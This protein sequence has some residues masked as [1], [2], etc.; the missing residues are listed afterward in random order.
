MRVDSI[1]LVLLGLLLNSCWPTEDYSIVP[2]IEYNKVLFR[3]IPNESD[4][5]VILIDFQ[6]GDGD[7]GLEKDE[8][9]SPFNDKAYFSYFPNERKVVKFY[10][11]TLTESQLAYYV[12]NLITYADRNIQDLD[13]LPAFKNPYS[14]I[15]WEI[16]PDLDT[17]Y[18][19][20][21]KSHY[22]IHVDFLVQ[23]TNGQYEEF[24]WER[25]FGYPN[26]G[27]S[28]N[29][30]FPILQNDIS[31]SRPLEGTI[32]YGMTS[33]GFKALFG[34]KRMKLRIQIIDRALNESNIVDTP[35]FTIPEITE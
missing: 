20:K 27:I 29:G 8:R 10:Y 16:I 14:C 11:D 15:N 30:R 9:G 7:L 34:I 22:N 28:Y 26:C 21:N 4:S 23:Q 19:Q 12:D 25:E 35:T 17:V 6:D 31:N 24:D 1:L 13:T 5:L 18:Y 33:A 32:R 3:D 2:F